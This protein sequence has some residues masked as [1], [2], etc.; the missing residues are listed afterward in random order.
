MTK[1]LEHEEGDDQFATYIMQQMVMEHMHASILK[2]K[3]GLR[4]RRGKRNHMQ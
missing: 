2:K 1:L 4:H 3:S